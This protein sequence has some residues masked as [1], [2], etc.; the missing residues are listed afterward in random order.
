MKS[1]EKII[2]SSIFAWTFGPLLYRSSLVKTSPCIKYIY[3]VWSCPSHCRCCIRCRHFCGRSPN[4]KFVQLSVPG[5][6]SER[7][8]LVAARGDEPARSQN[9]IFSAQ[10]DS[11]ECR[12]EISVRL[13]GIPP[14]SRRAPTI[15]ASCQERAPE[16]RFN[17]DCNISHM[18]EGPAPPKPPYAPWIQAVPTQACN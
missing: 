1:P 6:T 2:R 4:P 11:C 16:Q 12:F 5:S 14:V 3:R 8:S 7:G 17:K 13:C 10:K 9:A 18:V 15:V